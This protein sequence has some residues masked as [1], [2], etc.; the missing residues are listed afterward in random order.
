MQHNWSIRGMSWNGKSDQAVAVE[1]AKSVLCYLIATCSSFFLCV[2]SLI[3]IT[4]PAL[5]LTGTSE[6]FVL[7]VLAD[8]DHYLVTRVSAGAMADG[9]RSHFCNPE[10]PSGTLQILPCRLDKDNVKHSTVCLPVSCRLL[11]S[12][13]ILSSAWTFALLPPFNAVDLYSTLPSSLGSISACPLY[14]TRRL[15]HQSFS[16]LQ[17]DSYSL[18]PS[19]F[20][21]SHARLDCLC[22]HL[23]GISLIHNAAYSPPI[24]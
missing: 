24:N 20:P 23:S 9:L 10:I 14:S 1:L 8:S 16:I 19:S 4:C 12:F 18:S 2:P 15:P 22:L 17:G 11:V 13:G 6:L 5:T 21:F 7:S 3:S